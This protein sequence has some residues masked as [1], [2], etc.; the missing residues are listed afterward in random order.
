MDWRESFA[1]PQNLLRNLAKSNCQ[2]EYS[3]VPD[4]D[5]IPRRGLDQVR[6]LITL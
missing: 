4:V 1:Y 3:V 5:M 2:T 6:P